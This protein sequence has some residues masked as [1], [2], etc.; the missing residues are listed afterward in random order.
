MTNFLAE[1]SRLK[2]TLGKKIWL[3]VHLKKFGGQVVV[4]LHHRE[5][6]VKCHVF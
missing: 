2:N 5:T 6:N 1:L 3:S 4:R